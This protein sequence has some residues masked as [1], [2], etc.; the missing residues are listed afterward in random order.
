MMAR[1]FVVEDELSEQIL[2]KQALQEM[3]HEVQ[4]IDDTLEFE[5]QV[6]LKRPDLILM[7]INLKQRSGIV[8]MNDLKRTS[9]LNTIPIVVV[10]A[11]PIHHIHGKL[12]QLGC[13][14]FV[15]K[16]LYPPVLADIVRGA[17]HNG[18]NAAFAS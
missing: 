10:T 7:D 9:H 12:A 15:D 1:I 16:P 3:G 8:L 14:G 11:L 13:V 5:D 18:L 6:N 17:L 2:I 4:I